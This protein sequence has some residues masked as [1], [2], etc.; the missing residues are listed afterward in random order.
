MS[1]LKI[2]LALMLILVVL[3]FFGYGGGEYLTFSAI[4]SA[5]Q[6]LLGFV[7]DA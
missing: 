6:T 2:I 5:Q 3:L 4:K 1:R 7:A